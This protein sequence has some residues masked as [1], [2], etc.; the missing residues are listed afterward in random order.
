MCEIRLDWN[1]KCESL[2]R[3]ISL[4]GCWLRSFSQ[5]LE[6]R[7]DFFAKSIAHRIDMRIVL[8]HMHLRRKASRDTRPN[9]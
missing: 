9:W 7:P 4:L 3:Q 8:A 2:N 6:Q 5:R 1:S